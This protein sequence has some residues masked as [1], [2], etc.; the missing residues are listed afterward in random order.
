[1]PRQRVNIT[2]VTVTAVTIVDRES[3]EEFSE[4]ERGVLEYAADP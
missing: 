4:F 3:F 2:E 1:M